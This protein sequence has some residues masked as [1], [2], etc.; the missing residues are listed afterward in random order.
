MTFYGSQNFIRDQKHSASKTDNV[1]KKKHAFNPFGSNSV[2]DKNL[3]MPGSLLS[4]ASQ[5]MS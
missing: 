3:M 5:A 4:L 2:V 1:R